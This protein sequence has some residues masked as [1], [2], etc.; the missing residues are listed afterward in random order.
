MDGKDYLDDM[1]QTVS[2]DEFYKRIEEGAMPT[3]SQVNVGEFMDFFEPF[4]KAGK[5]VLHISFSSGLSGTYNAANIAKSELLTT[6]PDRKIHIVDSLGASSGYGLL[7]D[8]AA[9][10]RD[11]G[12]SIDGLHSLLEEN[13]L[14]VQHWF[15]STDLTHYKRGGRVSPTAAMVGTLLN[16]CPLLK[17]DQEGH[18]KPHEKIRGKKHAINGIVKK[19][20]QHAEGGNE[21][22]GKCFISQSACYEDARQVANQIEE[23]F[24]NLNGK[25]QINSIGTVIGAHTGPGTV[26]VF[27]MGEKR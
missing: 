22:S 3:T 6:Y 9:D 17:V 19:M 7:I 10:R 16:I 25:V 15:F 2:F 5:D 4:L 1:G 11:E 14:K 18:L 23:K 8:L 27:F 12:E 26:A 21:Y 20:E 24:P 13:K